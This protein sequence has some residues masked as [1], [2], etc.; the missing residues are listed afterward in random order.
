M[1]NKIYFLNLFLS[2]IIMSTINDF[3]IDQVE[4]LNVA[5]KCIGSASDMPTSVVTH[6][7]ML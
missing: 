4:T 5:R 7:Y 2:Y 1:T 3:D 6:L